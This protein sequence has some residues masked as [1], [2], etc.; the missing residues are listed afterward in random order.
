MRRLTQAEALARDSTTMWARAAQAFG[1]NG[2]ARDGVTAG[3]RAFRFPS[4]PQLES[5][6][7]SDLVRAYL[8]A[9]RGDD[10]R[11][12][13]RRID[14]S[15]LDPRQA[16]EIGRAAIDLGDAQDALPLLR[17]AT[18]RAPRNAAA[19][20]DLGVALIMANDPDAAL[21]ALQQAHR[22]DPREPTTLLDI[23]VIE[24]QKGDPAAARAHASEALRLQPG[25]AKAE[26]LLRLLGTR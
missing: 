25:Y 22:L 16:A 1:A 9:G 3:E 15:Q 17:S 23:A 20:H 10:A 24:A 14:P 4:T 5:T 7:A 13:L 2:D 8:T 26:G 18:A 19:Q 11:R 6:I 12:M 21:S